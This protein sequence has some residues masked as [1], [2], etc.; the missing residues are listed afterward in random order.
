[1]P[2]LKRYRQFISSK[3]YQIR[4]SNNQKHLN[5]IYSVFTYVNAS[6]YWLLNPLITACRVS[7]LAWTTMASFLWSSIRANRLNQSPR[8]CLF[9][10][11]LLSPN[12]F[13]VTKVNSFGRGSSGLCSAI[14][15]IIFSYF[16]SSDTIYYFFTLKSQSH[17][18]KVH[19]S[20]SLSNRFCH[21]EALIVAASND[22][23]SIS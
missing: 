10:L 13:H 17:F 12:I 22:F 14:E 19:Y 5:K 21:L 16:L 6:F 2:F 23:I 15:G 20:T 8:V 11:P 9:S 18:Y 7:N 3:N 4:S 1:M